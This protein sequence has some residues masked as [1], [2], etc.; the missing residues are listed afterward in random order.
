MS[1][2]TRTALRQVWT[3][4][5]W[6]L[7][8]RLHRFDYAHLLPSLACLP[9]P[10]AFGL[11]QLRGNIN[12]A[13][14]RDWR[15][16]A[17]GSRHI[18]RQSRLGYSQLPDGQDVTKCRRWV[19]ERFKVESRDELEAC[20]V[21][22]HRLH[23]LK[24]KFEPAMPGPRDPQRRG[25][26]LLTPHFDSFYLGIAFLAQATGWRTNSMSS[27]VSRDPRV[28]AAVSRHFDLKYRGLEHY[29]NGG[30]VLDMEVGLRPF[31]RMLEHGEVLVVLAD[32][33]VLPQ[34]AAM[35]VDF[36]G[37]PR[38]LAGGALRLARR[39]HSELG[40]FVCRRSPDGSYVLQV[41]RLG[42]AEDPQTIEGV[43]RFFSQTILSDPGSWWAADLLPHMP[44]VHLS[45]HEPSEH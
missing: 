7:L 19:T 3:A 36:L 44:L 17:L 9:R 21:A 15:S 34:G 1:P 27:A 24:C 23:E 14:G 33:P 30:K 26:V 32:A 39:T 2:P 43:Y 41:S 4:F 12:A 16:V 42:E 38:R 13:L 10:L 35:T 45:S 8:H 28:D 29:L 22:A 40:G 20:W 18:L 11:G 37:G 25:L 31:Y 5:K 6:S